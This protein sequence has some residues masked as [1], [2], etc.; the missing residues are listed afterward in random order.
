MDGLVPTSARK[1]APCL[2]IS[3]A[4]LQW[5]VTPSPQ[6]LLDSAELFLAILLTRRGCL[7]L[8]QLRHEKMEGRRWPVVTF[9]LIALNV[10]IFLGTHWTIDAIEQARFA[11]RLTVIM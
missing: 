10:A 1:C 4:L 3:H 7:M 8:I 5:P 2:S 11:V 6:G 9:V